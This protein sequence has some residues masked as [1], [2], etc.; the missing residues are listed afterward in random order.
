METSELLQKTILEATLENMDQG[1]SMVDADLK[2]IAFNAK[3]LVLFELPASFRI[4]GGERA[5]RR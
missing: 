1:I 2:F 3:L 5:G 4:G